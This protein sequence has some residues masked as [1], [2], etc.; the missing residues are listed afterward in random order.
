LELPPILEPREITHKFGGSTF[1]PHRSVSVGQFRST[2]KTHF[3]D[4]RL[5]EIG[6]YLLN[7]KSTGYQKNP[8]T[9]DLR[10]YHKDLRAAPEDRFNSEYHCRYNRKRV[11][12]FR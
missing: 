6:P 11:E 2:M 10:T 7:T 4:P 3:C 8:L 5:H 1:Y 9:N 12:Y